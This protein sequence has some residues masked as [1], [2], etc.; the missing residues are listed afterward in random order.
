MVGSKTNQESSR[1][2]HKTQLRVPLFEVD[3]GQAVYHGNY[4]HLFEL[5]R[6]A[7][8][9][10]LGYPYHRFMDQ[11]LHLAIVEASCSYRRPLHYDEMIEIHTGVKWWRRRSLA[12]SQAIYRSEGVEGWVLCTK[13]TLNMVCVRF[14][15]QATVLPIEFVDILKRSVGDEEATDME[16]SSNNYNRG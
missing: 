3:L 13:V 14:T 5:G 1:V 4:F 6:E 15:G 8:L 9:R 10:D 11:Q 12:L 2:W 16:A 7:F